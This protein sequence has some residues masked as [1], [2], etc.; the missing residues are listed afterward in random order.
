V[1]RTTLAA[2][3][4]VAAIVAANLAVTWFGLVPIAPGLVAPA[5][6]VFAGLVLLLRDTIRDR[7]LI[8]ILVAIGAVLSA[9]LSDPAIALASAAAFTVSELVDW[10]MFEWRR[11]RGASWVNAAFT[12]NLVSA[13]LDTIAF[14]WL[15]GFG[16][17]PALIAGQLLGKLI[18]ATVVPLL[19]K[20]AAERVRARRVVTA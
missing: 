15:S 16:L 17:A 5:G 11:R 12:S 20:A 19:V 3:G 4:Y 18:Y 8:A 9:L 14:L 7:R 6:V 10:A 13:P 2:V 1:N